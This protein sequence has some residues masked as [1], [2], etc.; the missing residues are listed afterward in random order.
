MWLQA[1]SPTRTTWIP[2]CCIRA[3][4]ASQRVSGHCS[5]YHAVPSISGGGCGAAVCPCS[6]IE[7]RTTLRVARKMLI[8]Q[9]RVSGFLFKAFSCRGYCGQKSPRGTCNLLNEG[10]HRIDQRGGY[11]KGGG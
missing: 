5:G 3:R 10:Q 8:F 11:R 6:P 2:A 4:S 7:A 1:N 9:Q